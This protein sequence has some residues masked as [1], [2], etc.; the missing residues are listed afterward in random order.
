M[1]SSELLMSETMRPPTMAVKT[2]AI[3]G[4][5]SALEMARQRG[6]AI[7]KTRKPEIASNRHL[8]ASVV[9]TG[10]GA[11]CAA[12]AWSDI[13]RPSVGRRWDGGC[14]TGPAENPKR[15]AE[16]SWGSLA[17]PAALNERRLGARPEFVDL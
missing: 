7:R 6:S 9:G 5:P 10:S 2:P 1:V 15:S 17:F 12:G 16:R 8:P 3:G 13:A 11:A 14:R 4:K